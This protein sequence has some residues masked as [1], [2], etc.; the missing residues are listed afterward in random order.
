M[1]L[2]NPFTCPNG[3]SFTANA[4]LRARCPECGAMAR[5]T[6]GTTK[7]KE[8]PAPKPADPPEPSD[9]PEP[10]TPPIQAKKKE[11]KVVRR[12]RPAKEPV[13]MSKPPLKVKAGLVTKRRLKVKAIPG[14]RSRPKG[15]REHKVSTLMGNDKPYWEQVKDKYWR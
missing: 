15:N 12:G 1:A 8:E 10:Q 9:P 5:K 3:H 11:I 7:P 4:K 13:R 2:S 14:I 6:F